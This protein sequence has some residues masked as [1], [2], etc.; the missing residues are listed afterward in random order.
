MATAP[1]P[2]AKRKQIL[3]VIFIS[4]LLDLVG[5][6]PNEMVQPLLTTLDFIHLHPPTIP[7]TPRV[8]P[9]HRIQPRLIE[10]DSQSDLARLEYLQAILLAPYKRS[11]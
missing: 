9:E 10:L 6:A 11:L 1:I 2:Q 4:L 7:E 3:R 5:G 8:L